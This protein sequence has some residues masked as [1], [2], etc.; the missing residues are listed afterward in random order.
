MQPLEFFTELY[1]RH[2]EGHL[3]VGR[4]DRKFQSFQTSELEVCAEYARKLD[5][6]RADVYFGVGLRSSVQIGHRRGKAS[7]V[8]GLV[9]FHLDVDCESPHRRVKDSV[10]EP[11]RFPP[12]LGDA[13]ELFAS[14]APDL[15]PTLFVNSG[16][17]LHAYW[18]LEEPWVVNSKGARVQAHTLIAGVQDIVRRKCTEKGWHLDNTSN[19]AQV[20]RVPGTHN[21]KDPQHPRLVE[22]LNY[23]G[24]RHRLATWLAAFGL[25]AAPSA[26]PELALPANTPPPRV[27][28]VWTPPAVEAAPKPRRAL[29]P[30]QTVLAYVRDCMFQNTKEPALRKAVQALLTGQP[31]ASRGGRNRT[32]LELASSASYWAV[33]VKPD[34]EADELLP[35]F[36]SSIAAMARLDADPSNPPLTIETVEDQLARQLADVLPKREEQWAAEDAMRRTLS[37]ARRAE[38]KSIL[39]HHPGSQEFRERVAQR[40]DE[41][42]ERG[43]TEEDIASFAAQQGC[44]VEAFKRRWIIKAAST[45]W[46]YVNGQYTPA[47]AESQAELSAWQWLQPANLVWDTPKVKGDGYRDKKWSEMLKDY[48]TAVQRVESTLERS[49]SR[50][51]P[52]SKTFYEAVAPVRDDLVPEFDPQVD[53]WLR[54]L[55][56]AQAEKLLDWVAV[57]TL[58]Q[59]QCCALYLK[60]GPGSGKGLLAEGLSR[61]WARSGGP[62]EMALVLGNYNERLAQMPL[63]F[64]DEHLPRINGRRGGLSAD[65]RNLVGST[66]RTLTRK[67]IVSSP[68]QGS[69]RFILAANNDSLLVDPSE[70]LST[71]DVDAY[72]GRFLYIDVGTTKGSAAKRYLDSIGNRVG[73]D[74][75]VSGSRIAKHALWLRD[76][77]VV[78]PGRRFIVEGDATQMHRS[79][80]TRT[81]IADAICDWLVSYAERPNLVAT[82]IGKGSVFIGNGHYFVTAPAISAS[83]SHYVKY[84]ETPSVAAIGRALST[85]SE[86]ESRNPRWIGGFQRRYHDIKVDT[87]LEWADTVGVGEPGKLKERIDAADASWITALGR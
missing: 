31:F 72:G 52:V 87:L 30:G 79:L 39:Q 11:K 48:A 7:D 18:C 13:L 78:V 23:R 36:E 15:H 61:I 27:T 67:Y 73:T 20:L 8:V 68:L 85:L 53:H 47:I 19:L 58:L 62:T 82:V 5:R 59:Y 64:A 86:S 9:G 12:T 38:V 26:P 75:W 51:D 37:L 66:S 35:L 45:Y 3:V 55:G 84:G 44:T 17:G 10:G 33:E 1:G 70:Q 57:V 29:A 2:R 76:N 42:L 24:P 71:E 83:W 54:C 22:V 4:L 32:C 56:G 21:W 40:T 14:W 81:R 74:D 43:Y 34:I 50:Y 49:V 63:V 69:L 6:E 41:E 77:R 80:A 46:F 65:L 16:Y 60:G 25:S 28:G